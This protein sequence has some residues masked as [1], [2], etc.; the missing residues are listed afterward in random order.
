MPQGVYKR[1][2]SEKEDNPHP[3][4]ID[5]KGSR[6]SSDQLTDFVFCADCED[7]FDRLGE[8]Y[9]MRMS[10]FRGRFRLLD[11]LEAI[12][13]SFEA[14]EFRGYSLAQDPSIKR[15]ELAYFA[16]SIFW[17]ASIH[18]WPSFGGGG[19]SVRIE[20]GQTANEGLRR[21]LLQESS[22][23]KNVSLWFVVC[24]DKVSQGSFNMPNLI[25][26]ENFVWKYGFMACGYL[27]QL[28][29][30]KTIPADIGKVCF[31]HSPEQWI[32]SRDCRGKTVEWVQSII[33]RQSEAVRQK[34]VTEL[35]PDG[36]GR[37]PKNPND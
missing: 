7:R 33:D 11:E 8:N 30:A 23:P 4:L 14:G 6:P 10:A 27:F 18:T 26:K 12:V 1:V 28:T 34:R 17:R 21:Y 16:L 29:V 2:R 5:V 37:G 3:I 13:P 19:Q 20:L 25:G 32:F 9:A 22:P 24:T 36:T 35:F 15:N 31:L